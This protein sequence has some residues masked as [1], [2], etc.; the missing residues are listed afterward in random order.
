VSDT[1]LIGAKVSPS[2]YA[3][4]R[5]AAREDA[6]SVSFILR[7]ALVKELQ[8][9]GYVLPENIGHQEPQDTGEGVGAAG[10][11]FTA[12]PRPAHPATDR[13]DLR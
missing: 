9:C 5:A 7:R 3:A 2:L 13:K 11:S 12:S 4:A 8:N 6:R 10:A 1:V